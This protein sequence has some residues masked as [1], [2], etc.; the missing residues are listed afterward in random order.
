MNALG[1]DTPLGQRP[2]GEGGRG[3]RV[4][5]KAK[6][7]D[8]SKKDRKRKQNYSAAH[9]AAVR[10]QLNVHAL[11]KKISAE[12]HAA[13][14]AKCV[15][16]TGESAS[17]TF[18]KGKTKPIST[19]SPLRKK[20]DDS[21]Q[22]G[23]QRKRVV[24]KSAAERD[25]CTDG[26]SALAQS[27]EN[28][29]DVGLPKGSA[30]SGDSHSDSETDSGTAEHGQQGRASGS[31]SEGH[32]ADDDGTAFEGPRSQSRSDAAKVKLFMFDFGE[33]DP[34]RCSG[35]KLYRHRRI[36]VIQVAQAK[37]KG[38]GV[39]R[40]KG[41]RGVGGG[42][43]GGT[44]DRVPAGGCRPVLASR[45]IDATEEEIKRTEESPE[46]SCKIPEER[47][48]RSHPAASPKESECP[49]PRLDLHTDTP[50]MSDAPPTS[51]NN[52]PRKHPGNR[53]RGRRGGFRGIVLTPFFKEQSKLL[54]AADAQLI[55]DEGLAV[56]DCSWNRVEEQG[57]SA[58]ISCSRANGRFLP[59][60]VAANPTHY[61][62]PYELNCVEALAAALMI[63]GYHDQAKDLLKLFKWGMNF[64]HL[65]DGALTQYRTHGVD[66]V[67]MY[68]T[69]Q[70][71]LESTEGQRAA[72]RQTPLPLPSADES[73]SE[74]SDAAD[75]AACS[76]A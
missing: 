50:P 26:H 66:E 65:N 16:E 67:S 43:G 22:S 15:A 51:Q 76:P 68:R 38:R 55:R 23:A 40:A 30:G 63:V 9:A 44:Y 29:H 54:S 33:C 64:I 24:R 6:D 5:D 17:S 12:K 41:S 53:R 74:D 62:R 60:L 72:A 28:P 69:E 59:Y 57:K 3:S 45:G 21:V 13:A 34:K 71:V 18:C 56:V 11:V 4:G 48:C 1:T 2:G 61:G 14:Q 27:S 42:G 46:R 20:E 75:A 19:L 58:R 36:Q 25:C 10:S 39:E 32:G 47:Q 52:P 31:S 70:S 8:A 49:A 35:R 73:S 7:S 37:A